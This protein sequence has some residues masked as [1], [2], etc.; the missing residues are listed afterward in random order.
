MS[1]KV[2]LVPG[3]L[4]FTHLGAVQYFHRV[5]EVLSECLSRRNGNSEVIYA[6]TLPAGS[7]RRR[8]EA[9]FRTIVRHGGGKAE[10]ISIIGHSTG[11]LDARMVATPSVHFQDTERDEEI[12]K[13][14]R[15]VVTIS[16]PH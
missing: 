14:I 8:S 5:G 11:G 4:G 15:H 3:F 13:R 7:I 12:V 1:H 10:N 6:E 9:L 2:I 16:T